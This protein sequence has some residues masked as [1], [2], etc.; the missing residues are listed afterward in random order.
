LRYKIVLILILSFIFSCSVN[1]NKTERNN[2]TVGVISKYK[3]ANNLF[4]TTLYQINENK[5]DSNDVCKIDEML[6]R[7]AWSI[8]GTFEKT[9]IYHISNPFSFS[10][11]QRFLIESSGNVTISLIKEKDEKKFYEIFNQHLKSGFYFLQ[12]NEIN[13]ASGKYSL[14]IKTTQNTIERKIEFESKS[15]E[16]LK[17]ISKVDDQKASQNIEISLVYSTENYKL[18]SRLFKLNENTKSS[19]YYDKISIINFLQAYQINENLIDPFEDYKKS[20]PYSPTNDL[21]FRVNKSSKVIISL[22]PKNDSNNSITLL[23]IFLDEGYYLLSFS[24]FIIEDGLYNLQYLMN[25]KL[26]EKDIILMK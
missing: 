14:I 17:N 6:L 13:I 15:S 23:N 16:S 8:D 1:L 18:A 12:F 24:K 21:R 2:K 5:N 10:N 3:N 7:R 4:T 26:I 19:K 9:D 20:T 11:D 22:S 25:D